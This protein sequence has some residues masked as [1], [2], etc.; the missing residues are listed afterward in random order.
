[1]L[2]KSNAKKLQDIDIK[3]IMD[4]YKIMSYKELAKQFNVNP[5]TISNTITRFGGKK[6]ISPHL[7]ID[8]SVKV[9]ELLKLG[10]R[11]IDIEKAL[12][13]SKSKVRQI[14]INFNIDIKAYY[15]EEMNVRHK[16]KED[17]GILQVWHSY[18]GN[19][20]NRKIKFDLTFDQFKQ[21]VISNCYYCGEE[22]SN[23]SRNRSDLTRCNYN[24]IDKKYPDQGYTTENSLPCCWECNRIKSDIP[25]D[26]FIAKIKNISQRIK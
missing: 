15:T 3:F 7:T 19:A 12:N 9:I 11:L 24:G 6:R 1:M 20:L 2:L 25:Y 8:Y 23:V 14:C 21:L 16:I 26:K 13:L 4:N 10:N 5:Q 18:R 22:P 17:A